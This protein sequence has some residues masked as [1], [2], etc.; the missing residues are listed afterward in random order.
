MP[1]VEARPPWP[2]VLSEKERTSATANFHCERPAQICE[3]CWLPGAAAIWRQRPA[4]EKAILAK[5]LWVA[6]RACMPMKT[7]QLVAAILP[8]FRIMPSGN[9]KSMEAKVVLQI[10]RSWKRYS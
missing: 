4:L 6:Q 9:L 3:V 7:Q 2:M 8:G 1:S 10:G 5:T